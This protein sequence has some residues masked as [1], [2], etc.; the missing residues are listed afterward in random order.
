[1]TNGDRVIGPR[2]RA[3]ENMVARAREKTGIRSG[4]PACLNCRVTLWMSFF[5]DGTNN[6]S[7]NVVCAV[8]WVGAA[9]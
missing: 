6:H 1:M 9:V 3:V 8:E 5:F 7:E 4:G 2:V